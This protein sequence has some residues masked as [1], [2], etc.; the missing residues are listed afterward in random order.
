[1]TE[2]EAGKIRS[3]FCN[4][5]AYPFGGGFIERCDL[6]EVSRHVALLDGALTKQIPQRPLPAPLAGEYR[7]PRCQGSFSGTADYCCHCGQAL[8]WEG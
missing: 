6:D 7:C 4:G 3:A 5:A 1:M 2:K 8:D